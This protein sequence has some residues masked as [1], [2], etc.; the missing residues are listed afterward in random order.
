M[1]SILES[2]VVNDKKNKDKDDSSDEDSSKEEEMDLFVKCYNQY[3]IKHK[4]KYSDKKL[5]NF[6][7]SH[8]HKK[9]HK[10]K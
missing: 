5:I 10:R 7:K 4:L 1:G 9:E 6:K 3:M 8:P 2:F